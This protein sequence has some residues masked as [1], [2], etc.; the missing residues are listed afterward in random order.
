MIDAFTGLR[1]TDGLCAEIREMKSLT[2]YGEAEMATSDENA[3]PD[4]TNSPIQVESVD[5]GGEKYTVDERM[6]IQLHQAQ[7]PNVPL[8]DLPAAI[9]YRVNYQL[10]TIEYLP[11]FPG[12]VTVAA[13]KMNNPSRVIINYQAVARIYQISLRAGRLRDRSITDSSPVP[14]AYIIAPAFSFRS[15]VKTL[16][17][18]F[19][20]ANNL[21][22]EILGPVIEAERIISH[23]VQK[24]A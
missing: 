10:F 23:L 7:V 12:I 11:E 15:Q 19:V 13:H 20:E 21:G 2:T 5:L 8:L 22:N 24:W 18:M 6:F 9:R 3:L 17:K 4:T 14:S 16:K 1:S